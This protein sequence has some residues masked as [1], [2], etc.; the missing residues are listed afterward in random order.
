MQREAEA[1]ITLTLGA[2]SPIKILVCLV[3]IWKRT[4]C[5]NWMRGSTVEKK[6]F[7]EQ[8]VIWADT[9]FE[10]YEKYRSLFSFPQKP[11][12]TDL[13]RHSR[14]NNSHWLGNDSA[15]VNHHSI[16]RVFISFRQNSAQRLFNQSWDCDS[17]CELKGHNSLQYVRSQRKSHSSHQGFIY[18]A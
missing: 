13:S 8:T 9:Q 1:C 7:S 3:L 10:C 2:S 17:A 11:V 16:D 18:Y 12:V 14:E 5:C 4:F 6:R 15:L